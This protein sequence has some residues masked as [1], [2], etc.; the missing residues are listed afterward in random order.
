MMIDRYSLYSFCL[1]KYRREDAYLLLDYVILFVDLYVF[2][3]YSLAEKGGDSHD[4]KF[5]KKI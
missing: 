4:R 3:W 1:E 5:I 2:L